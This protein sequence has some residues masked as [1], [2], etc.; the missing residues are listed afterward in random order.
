VTAYVLSVYIHIL[1]ATVWVGGIAFLVLVIVPALRRADRAAALP[2]MRETVMRFR[3]V[4]WCAFAVLVVTGLYNLHARAIGWAQLSS[5]AW[6]A[7][8]LGRALIAKLSLFAG[9]LVLSAVHDFWIGPRA[10]RALEEAPDAPRTKRLRHATGWIGR[11][12]GLATIVIVFLAV[13]LVRGCPG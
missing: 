5:A 9:V 7:T 12:N 6:R 10:M 3:T 13:T 11:I 8:P 2:M 4:G 1:A